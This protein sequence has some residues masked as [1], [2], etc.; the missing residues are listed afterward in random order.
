VQA[1]TEGADDKAQIPVD[2]NSVV[3]DKYLT[4]IKYTAATRKLPLGTPLS[5]L[6]MASETTY[7]LYPINTCYGIETY[8]SNASFTNDGAYN[9]NS[10]VW[11]CSGNGACVAQDRCKCLN[12]FTGE[13]CQY[14]ICNGLTVS[15]QEKLFT[16]FFYFFAHALSIQ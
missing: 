6:T 12:G 5:F 4:K 16:I 3:F 9:Y 2:Y 1:F 10:I 7:I 15:L 8:P 14:A 13:Q 11:P